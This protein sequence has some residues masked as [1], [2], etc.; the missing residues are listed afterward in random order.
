MQ[1][2]CWKG[3]GVQ[4]SHK[5]LLGWIL[6]P[7][8][9]KKDWRQ[10]WE[11]IS[12]PLLNGTYIQLSLSESVL[13]L[14]AHTFQ[15]AWAED[16]QGLLLSLQCMEELSICSPHESLHCAKILGVFEYAVGKTQSKLN[17]SLP[18][19]WYMWV[20]VTYLFMPQHVGFFNS[21]I[22]WLLIFT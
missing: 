7:L 8:S 16:I 18:N 20:H 10:A 11:H 1:C 12:F 6:F 13:Q 4:Q 5:S 15:K 9:P 21:V 19:C 14:L 22:S 2:S 3:S 17:I